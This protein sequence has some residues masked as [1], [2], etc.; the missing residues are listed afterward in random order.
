MQRN[1][2]GL[3]HFL[4][5]LVV[6]VLLIWTVGYISIIRLKEKGVLKSVVLGETSEVNESELKSE[7]SGLS[8]IEDLNLDDLEK[9]SSESTNTTEATKPVPATSFSF[10]GFINYLFESFMIVFKSS[11]PK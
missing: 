11:L 4:P 9:G 2:K 6:A 10:F 8:E 7:E 1:A 3:I 5:L